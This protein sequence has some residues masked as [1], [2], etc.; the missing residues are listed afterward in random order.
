M[1]LI[2]VID[3]ARA[4]INEPLES[5]R[6]FPDNTSSFWTDTIL[7]T[8]HNITQKEV[9]NDVVQSFEDYF[10]TET[11]VDI[12]SG[13]TEYTLPA[14]FIKMRRVEDVRNTSRPIEIFPISLGD[15]DHNSYPV[16]ISGTFHQRGYYIKGNTLAFD[17]TPTFSQN[18]AVK[19]Y[20]IKALADVTAGTNTS[21]IPGEF[22]QVLV[23]GVVKIALQQQQSDNNFAIQEYE[24]QLQKMRRQAE[25]RQIQRPRRVKRRRDHR[26]NTI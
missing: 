8:Y 22:H 6:T 16:L 11:T 12:V 20:Y 23:W 19:L 26:R 4:I 24:K 10:V 1:T 25:D 9:Q 5:S 18:S 2:E 21:E 14:N 17:D 3:A 13:T 7:T 15:K